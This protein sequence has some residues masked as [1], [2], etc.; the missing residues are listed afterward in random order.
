MVLALVVGTMLLAEPAPEPVEAA[1]SDAVLAPA[2]EAPPSPVEPLERRRLWRVTAT[3]LGGAVGVAAPLFVADA[4]SRHAAPCPMFTFCQPPEWPIA[5]GLVPLTAGLGLSVP[6]KLMD[7]EAGI[8]FGLG[9]AIAGYMTALAF[10]GATSWAA[11]T[12]W[13]LGNTVAGAGFATALGLAGAVI[14]FE[15]R[16][17][18]LAEGAREWRLGRLLASGAAF[19]LPG[20]LVELGIVVLAITV[21]YNNAGS[22]AAICL[23]GSLTNAF[24]ASLFGWAAHRGL[25]GKAPFWVAGLGALAG[26]AVGSAFIA[27]HAHGPPSGGVFTGGTQTGIP[28]ALIG[29]LVGL[30]GPPAALEWAN[31]LEEETD[32]LEPP[33]EPS[34]LEKL[35]VQL[36]VTPLQGGAALGFNG[37][38]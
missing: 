25:G 22:L 6:Y 24:G 4:I 15:W 34:P 32:V 5:V 27:L 9:G 13:A 26:V 14:G 21:S 20:G 30:A 29:V 12:P 17:S 2:V 28:I 11:G 31:A 38:F 7:G 8:G 18:L 1:P 36:G 10:M 37:R 35:Q 19:W 33:Q 23:F 16:H 3:L